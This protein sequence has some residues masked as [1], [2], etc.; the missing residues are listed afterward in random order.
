MYIDNIETVL[1][2]TKNKADGV[3]DITSLADSVRYI[4]LETTDESIIGIISQVIYYDGLFFIRDNKSSSILVFEQTGKYKFKISK[5]GRGPGEYAE[6]TRMLLDRKN[7][8]ILIYDIHSRKMLYYTFDGKFVKEI[9][10]INEKGIAR[11]VI[12]LPDGGFLCYNPYNDNKNY[13]PDAKYWGVWKVDSSGKYCKHV[14]TAEN[15]YPVYFRDALFFYELPDNKTGLWCPDI[16][17]VL[18]FSNDTVIYRL[19]MKADKPTVSDFPGQTRDDISSQLTTRLKVIETDNFIFG[20]WWDASK[21]Y[22]D[23]NSW[24]FKKEKKSVVTSGLRYPKDSGFLPG[25]LVH[26]NCTDQM[27]GVISVSMIDSIIESG[28]WSDSDIATLKS[29]F[30]NPNDDNPVLEILY[31]KK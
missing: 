1:L 20:E 10:H 6:M 8:R 3:L 21:D 2:D 14:W 15:T 5:K 27:L 17:D 26:F 11:D 29:L 19:S 18:H 25:N 4:K 12:Q 31:L 30:S 28:Y 24:Y 16:N 7:R 13:K 9:F 22:V 23:I